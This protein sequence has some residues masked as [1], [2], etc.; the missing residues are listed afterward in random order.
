MI[1]YLCFLC[2]VCQNDGSTRYSLEMEPR[3]GDWVIKCAC[4]KTM[5]VYIFDGQYWMAHIL[6]AGIEMHEKSL[7]T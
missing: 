6:Q 2:P 3:N 7:A 1:D 5:S 4:C